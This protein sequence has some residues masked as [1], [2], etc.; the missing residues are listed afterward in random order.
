MHACKARAAR[1]EHTWPSRVCQATWQPRQP[2]PSGGARARAVSPSGAA[3][4]FCELCRAPC[5]QCQCATRVRQTDSH[6]RPALVHG[7]STRVFGASWWPSRSEALFSHQTHLSPSPRLRTLCAG[8]H[9]CAQTGVYS[10]DAP[11][12]ASALAPEELLAPPSACTNKLQ[13][14]C[15]LGCGER[16]R[17]AARRDAD[18]TGGPEQPDGV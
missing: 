17:R 13:R 4:E 12:L 16:L 8:V 7:P 5:H 18:G 10:S 15:T 3:C 11:L 1:R 14:Q 9:A 2:A 6:A